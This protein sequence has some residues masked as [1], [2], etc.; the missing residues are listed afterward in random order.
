MKGKIAIKWFDILD[1]TNNEAARHLESYDNMSVIAAR[2]QTSG[3]GQRGNS[4]YSEYGKNLMFSMVF[5]FPSLPAGEQFLVSRAV[6]LGVT[7]Y[8][9]GHGIQAKI[10]WPNDI[11]VGDR[12]ICGILIENSIRG[13]MLY[14]SIAGVGFNL[15]QREWGDKAPNPTSLALEL[16]PGHDFAPDT[17]LENIVSCIVSRITGMDISGKMKEEYENKMYRINETHRYK[18]TSSGIIFDGTITGTTEKGTLLVKT[19]EG[20]VKEFAFK[21]IG[22]IIYPQN[23][24]R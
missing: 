20:T 8:V 19:S 9:Q 12:K 17:E 24:H 10:K 13:G 22:Y 11:Y 3:K 1:S 23:H 2:S 16:N 5:K 4:W 21:E 7:D 6:A 14:S 15:N 18:E